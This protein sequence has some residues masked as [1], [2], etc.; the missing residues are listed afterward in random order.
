MRCMTRHPKLAQEMVY[1]TNHLKADYSSNDN[2]ICTPR[3]RGSTSY[4]WVSGPKD[5]LQCTSSEGLKWGPR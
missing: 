2:I 5:R 3:I 4:R 1:G